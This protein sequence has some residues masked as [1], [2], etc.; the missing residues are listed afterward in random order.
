MKLATIRTG[1]GATVA[2]RI[3]SD[4]A[5]ELGVPDVSTLLAG[6]DWRQRA[7]ESGP[8]HPVDG[9]DYATLLPSPGKTFCVGLNYRNHIL[10]TGR[11]L[12]EYP[13]LFAKFPEALIGA[14]DEIALPVEDPKMDWEAE[15]GV[16]IGAP[17]RRVS[18]E[19][20]VAGIVGY[21]VVNDIS[22]RSFQNRTIEWLQGKTFENSTPVGPHLVTADEFDGTS[23]EI[24]CEVNGE[25]MQ[26]SDIGDLLFGPAQLV[27]YISTIITLRPGDL[28]VSGT[29]GGVGNAR[30]PPVY[31]D[32]GDVVVTRVA[33]LGECR[34]TCRRDG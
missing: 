9:L 33:G 6:Q 7:Q 5:V 21:T 13:T 17:M 3:D 12:P 14:H 34:N 29:P 31:L 23:G 8:S 16:V 15:L 2:V 24:V 32:E 25:T 11:D 10:E 19:D 27:S 18:P 20:A 30:K 1:S 4:Q 22:A 26:Q 28:I